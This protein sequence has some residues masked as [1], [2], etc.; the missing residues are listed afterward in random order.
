MGIFVI[1]TNVLVVANGDN[2]K[3]DESCQISCIMKIKSLL[4]GEI[5]VLD[6]KRIIMREYTK[7]LRNFRKF[8]NSGGKGR[9]GDQFLFYLFNNLYDSSRVHRVAI[10]CYS[11]DRREFQELPEN[12]LKSGDRAILAV[13]VA[14]KPPAV[15]VNATD[16]DWIEQKQ[17]VDSLGVKVEQLCPQH[18]RKS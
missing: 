18:A 16:S 9:L 12:K 5:I 2:D 7:R 3:V 13:A 17:L 15:I 11:D 1:D 10:T 4:K 6:D 8:H 14:S